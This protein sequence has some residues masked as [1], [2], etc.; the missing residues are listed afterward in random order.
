MIAFSALHFPLFSNFKL[1]SKSPTCAA[2]GK[3]GKTIGEIQ[4][5]DY[6]QWCGAA[7]DWVQ[8]GLVDGDVGHRIRVQ[9]CQ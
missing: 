6:V 3:E 2:C 4:D 8:K 5:I 7:P 1:G 9:V